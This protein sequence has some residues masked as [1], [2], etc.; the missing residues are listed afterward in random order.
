MPSTFVVWGSRVESLWDPLR[1]LRKEHP[2]FRVLGLP[3]DS[4][5]GRV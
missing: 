1:H 5:H 2:D 4:A 3:G